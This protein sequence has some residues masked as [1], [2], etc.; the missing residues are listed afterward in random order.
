MRLLDRLMQLGQT[1]D[2]VVVSRRLFVGGLAAAA[3]VTVTGVSLFS[4]RNAQ[5]AA[6]MTLRP[7]LD[8]EPLA[9]EA[10][11]Q[12]GRRRYSRREL[13]RR[14]RRDRRFFRN[15]RRLCSR[16]D[17]RPGRRGSCVEIGPVLLCD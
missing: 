12:G 16:V 13:R 10:Q 3:V 4:T 9:D 8:E 11:F 5:A 15:N 7:D 17:G 2:Q 6:P 14:C 1:D